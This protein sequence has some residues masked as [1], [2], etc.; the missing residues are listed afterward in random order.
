MGARP[1]RKMGHGGVGKGD[2]DSGVVGREAKG[3]EAPDERRP[4]GAGKMTEPWAGRRE[5]DSQ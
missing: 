5:D 4:S 1:F 2:K 3:T